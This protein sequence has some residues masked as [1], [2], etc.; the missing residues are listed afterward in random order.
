[1]NLLRRTSV[2]VS[3]IIALGALSITQAD[4]IEF[5]LNYSLSLAPISGDFGDN[6]LLGGISTFFSDEA[7]YF[8]LG[9][10]LIFNILFDKR[11]QVFEFEDPPGSTNQYFSFGLDCGFLCPQPNGGFNGTWESSIEPL[12]GRGNIWSDP[13]TIEW[14]CPGCPIVGSGTGFGWGGQGL[15]ITDSQ[16]SF[17]GIRWTTTLTG[18]TEGGPLLLAGFTGVQMGADGIRVL[19]VPEPSTLALLVLGLAGMRLARRR[20]SVSQL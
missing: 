20:K 9:D 16:G 14:N 13:I 3:S 19:P 10:T 12:G 15:E 2:V 17:T 18:V 11:L 1:M 7:F 6:Q 4:T 8:G 5:D